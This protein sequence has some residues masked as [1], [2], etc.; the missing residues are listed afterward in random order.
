MFKTTRVNSRKHCCESFPAKLRA[1]LHCYALVK[2]VTPCWVKPT[3]LTS[4]ET[5]LQKGLVAFAGG[6]V[7][8]RRML[9]GLCHGSVKVGPV[10]LEGGVEVILAREA[11]LW[12]RGMYTFPP[13]VKS[14]LAAMTQLQSRLAIL[15]V[16]CQQVPCE[17]LQYRT[18]VA[19]ATPC[20]AHYSVPALW[21][22]RMCCWRTSSRVSHSVNA[23]P[24]CSCI[25][26]AVIH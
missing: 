12:K 6:D 25:A 21:V 7:G 9:C 19:C 14:V 18:W 1:V 3:N 23:S 24:Q 16:V 20:T 5:L 13:A 4:D 10:G 2:A 17:R 26:T 22:L 8:V 11:V 15:E